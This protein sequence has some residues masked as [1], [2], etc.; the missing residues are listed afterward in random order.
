MKSIFNP[1][2]NKEIIDR[3]NR[4]SSGS[5]AQWGKMN[6]SQMLA[7][8]QIPI[9]VS[10][11]EIKL[12]RGLIGTLFGSLAK[13]QLLNDKPFKKNLPTDRSFII[14]GIPDFEKEK[15]S[16]MELVQRLGKSSTN[17]TNEPHPFFGKMKVNE[18]DTL[19]IK[20]LDHHL[21]QF[22]V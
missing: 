16:L 9:K 15:N 4:L 17:L 1:G 2:D 20:H 22:G 14:Q 18:W 6:D 3:I 8:A 19:M 13:K 12:K 10:L 5:T 11:G 21:R 7:H